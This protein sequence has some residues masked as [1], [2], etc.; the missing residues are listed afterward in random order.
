MVF[1]G[2]LRGAQGTL[3]ILEGRDE[4]PLPLVQNRPK[5]GQRWSTALVDNS[6]IMV[7]SVVI[8]LHS[9]QRGHETV[10]LPLWWPH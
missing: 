10:I 4:V 1:W 7:S 5:Q 2:H 3:R 8:A 9:I 6:L